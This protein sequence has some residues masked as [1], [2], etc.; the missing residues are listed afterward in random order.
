MLVNN[1]GQIL[2]ALVLDITKYIKY[3]IEKRDSPISVRIAFFYGILKYIH[4]EL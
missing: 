4:T 1:I 3:T 2:R